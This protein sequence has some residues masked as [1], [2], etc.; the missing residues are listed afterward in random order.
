[1]PGSQAFERVPKHRIAAGALVGRE[2]ALEHRALRPECGDAGL[3]IRLPRLRQILRGGW[4]GIVEEIESDHPHAEAAEL[5]I[6][7]GKGGDLLDQ[8]APLLER[9]VTLA[10]IGSD[11]DRA[12]DMVEYNRRLREAARQ[13]DEV[14]ELGL[15]HP[16]FKGEIEPGWGGYP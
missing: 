2:I 6:G 10:G 16:R 14:A 7:V 4:L 9:L 11:R 15:E 3:D 12:A 5:D 1:M 13:I 8:P